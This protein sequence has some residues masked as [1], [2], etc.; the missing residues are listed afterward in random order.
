MTGQIPQPTSIEERVDVAL[1]TLEQ[2]LDEAL[3]ALVQRVEALEAAAGTRATTER[4]AEFRFGYPPAPG[5]PVDPER[6][7]Q[8]WNRLHEWVR[9]LAA[10][11][12]LTALLPPCWPQHPVLVE[13][14]TA[15][16]LAWDGAWKSSA[17]PEAP[18][19]FLERLDRARVRWADTNWGIPRCDGS[20]E[21]GGLDAPELYRAWNDDDR[22]RSSLLAARDA[23][24]ARLRQQDGDA[25]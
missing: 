7:L 25:A 6:S 1:D 24:I 20:H 9:W 23:T 17:P 19:A 11:F 22:Q 12:R 21:P 16:Y 13:E 3:P 4:R 2:L 18:S 5:K 10:Q 8:A 15:L 14:L